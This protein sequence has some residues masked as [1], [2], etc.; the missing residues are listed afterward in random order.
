MKMNRFNTK[1]LSAACLFLAL[2]IGM[3]F[4][5]RQSHRTAQPEIYSKISSAVGA[6]KNLIPFAF[7]PSLSIHENF[8]GPPISYDPDDKTMGSMR[9]IMLGFAKA[10]DNPKHP[11]NPL[12]TTNARI[13]GM[14]IKPLSH[15]DKSYTMW[16]SDGAT[17]CGL[18]VVHFE[19]WGGYTQTG[20][21]F[22]RF[23]VINM[24]SGFGY[25]SQAEIDEI[26][27]PD[28][29][30]FWKQDIGEVA[31]DMVVD[32]L[33]QDFL[34]NTLSQEYSGFFVADALNVVYL[35]NGFS[36]NVFTKNVVDASLRRTDLLEANLFDYANNKFNIY[37]QAEPS[38]SPLAF[39]VVYANAF[40]NGLYPSNDKSLKQKN[41]VRFR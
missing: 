30:R 9:Q 11:C 23:F 40:N 4:F 18:E 28:K 5:N 16:I 3:I 6:E 29:K 13:V 19:G 15:G 14:N 32:A 24:A 34:N 21:F 8:F 26:L 10:M 20:D 17:T 38:N 2:L 25:N 31:H 39:K 33:G 12:N 1:W 36:H 41:A 35:S 7:D 27:K 22:H 37:I